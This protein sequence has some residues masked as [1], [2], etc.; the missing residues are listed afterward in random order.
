LKLQIQHTSEREHERVG[1]AEGEIE[2]AEIER[3]DTAEGSKAS[4][5][6]GE[7]ERRGVGGK[8]AV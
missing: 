3:E 8:A 4:W 2:D 5:W 7:G 1:G 6:E